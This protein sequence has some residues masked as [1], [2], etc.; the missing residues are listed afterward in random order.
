[1][2][3]CVMIPFKYWQYYIASL[4]LV[5]FSGINGCALPSK[6]DAEK[7]HQ[8]IRQAK[9]TEVCLSFH[10][11]NKDWSIF[12]F[13]LVFIKLPFG[14]LNLIQKKLSELANNGKGQ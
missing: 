2:C 9:H 11:W 1:M 4:W 7:S 10:M 12:F 14:S 6:T 5:F 8:K 13:L 3:K